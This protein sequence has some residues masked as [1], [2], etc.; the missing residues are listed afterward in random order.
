MAKMGFYYNQMRCSGCRTCQIAC[1]DKNDL[2]VGMLFRRVGTYE[3]GHY[4][5]ALVYSIS[6]TCNHCLNPSCVGACPSG[7]MY[8]DGEDG[9]VQHDDAK[10]IACQYCVSACPYGNPKYIPELNIVHKCDGC[11]TLR[12]NG[13]QPACVAA[14]IMRALEFGPYEELRSRYPDAVS[15]LAVLPDSSQTDPCTLIAARAAALDPDPV[16]KHL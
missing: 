13:E 15:D 1:K 11:K 7:A 14:C 9:T 2:P 8:V 4:P 3:V 16:E 10:C 5:G 6:Q 12:G